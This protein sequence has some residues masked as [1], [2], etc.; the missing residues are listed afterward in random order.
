MQPA[1]IPVLLDELLDKPIAKKSD[2]EKRRAHQR[3]PDVFAPVRRL[4][5]SQ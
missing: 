4:I 3:D 5:R 1:R 2:D